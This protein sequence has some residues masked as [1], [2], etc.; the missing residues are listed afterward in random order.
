M[1]T[2]GPGGGCQGPYTHMQEMGLGPEAPRSP[3]VAL[4]FSNVPPSV[5][6][7]HHRDSVTNN[8]PLEFAKYLV[9]CIRGGSRLPSDNLFLTQ[10]E[11]IG[12]P[13]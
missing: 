3:E 7:G 11:S 6:S 13:E 8:K 9:E 4:C 10:L 2:A 5:L 1:P 12:L